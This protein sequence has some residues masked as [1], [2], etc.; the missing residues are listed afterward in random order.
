MANAEVAQQFA[1]LINNAAGIVAALAW[2]DALSNLFVRL[3]ILKN[4]PMLG[5]VA[6]A[7]VLTLVAYAISRAL[8]T[9][10]KPACTTLCSPDATR[11]PAR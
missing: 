3:R 6:Y 5:P 7:A 2:S 11:A 8:S 10:A 9:Y 1:T 4:S